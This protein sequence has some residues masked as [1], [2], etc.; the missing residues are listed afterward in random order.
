MTANNKII[1]QQQQIEVSA[2]I[3]EYADEQIDDL[4]TTIADLSQELAN[5]ASANQIAPA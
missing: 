2:Q 4:N 3:I 5:I 1:E